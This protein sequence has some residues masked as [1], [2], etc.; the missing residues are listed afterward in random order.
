MILLVNINFSYTCSYLNPLEFP[1]LEV[2]RK[3]FKAN[4]KTGKFYNKL[5]TGTLIKPP[6]D[7]IG[8]IKVSLSLE[9]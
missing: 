6:Q 8:F 4:P 2:E 9:S 7:D 1:D 3:Y 5:I